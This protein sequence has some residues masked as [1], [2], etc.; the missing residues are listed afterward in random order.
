MNTLTCSQSIRRTLFVL[1]ALALFTATH[2]PGLA[3]ASPGFSRLDLLIH[4]GVFAGWTI[5]FTACGVFGPALSNRN[6]SRSIPVALLYAL[7]DELTQGIPFLRRTVDPLDLAA[8]ATGIVLAA[9]GLVL[10]TRARR[11]PTESSK[12]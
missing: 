2:W 11:S 4:A 12:Q 7:L 3:I 8:N 9:L 10:W 6:I 5:L 1:Y